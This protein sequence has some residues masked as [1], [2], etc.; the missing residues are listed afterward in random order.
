MNDWKPKFYPGYTGR[1]HDDKPP[2][3]TRE[4]LGMLSFLSG[5][6]LS[7]IIYLLLRAAT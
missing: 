3:L 6:A 7:T 2:T 1:R 5:M 4:Q